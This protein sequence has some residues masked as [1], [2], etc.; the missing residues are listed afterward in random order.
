LP[1]A[2]LQAAGLR[3]GQALLGLWDYHFARW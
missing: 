2:D 3:N 1:L